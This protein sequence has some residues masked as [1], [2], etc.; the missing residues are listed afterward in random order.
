[1]KWRGEVTCDGW[2]VGDLRSPN[3]MNQN[4]PCRFPP[5]FLATWTD[6]AGVEH[7]RQCCGVHRRRFSFATLVPLTPEL[8]AA[9]PDE[10]QQ[11]IA[12]ERAALAIPSPNPPE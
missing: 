6:K 8:L 7:Q 5:K 12:G 9:V 3:G 2:I 10:A 4:A 11:I 1:M